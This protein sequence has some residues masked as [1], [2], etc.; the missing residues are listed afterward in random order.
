M[1]KIEDL[2]LLYGQITWDQV[3]LAM[4][5][6][7]LQLMGSKYQVLRRYIK[8]NLPS[9]TKE[10]LNE[11][12]ETLDKVMEMISKWETPTLSCQTTMEMKGQTYETKQVVLNIM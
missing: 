12:R 11:P 8:M 4:V 7:A 3:H 6:W 2:D 10:I 1:Q 5:L 9:A